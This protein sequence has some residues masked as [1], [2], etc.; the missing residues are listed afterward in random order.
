MRQVSRPEGRTVRYQLVYENE[1]R[2]ERSAYHN[3]VGHGDPP[4]SDHPNKTTLIFP[5]SPFP[6]S[7]APSPV[8]SHSVVRIDTIA[9]LMHSNKFMPGQSTPTS[10]HCRTTR[11]KSSSL[12][13]SSPHI[14]TF[15]SHPLIFPHQQLLIYIKCSLN[16]IEDSG[17]Q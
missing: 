2:D 11:T 8:P 3:D 5:S 13:P 12:L 6:C 10:S 15:F 7:F 9:S 17:D 1:A 16:V 14:N 4:R